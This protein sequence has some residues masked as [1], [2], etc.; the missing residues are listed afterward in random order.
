MGLPRGRFVTMP[1]SQTVLT[2][3]R[4]YPMLGQREGEMRSRLW[5][6]YVGHGGGRHKKARCWLPR[7]Y[8][9]MSKLPPK[10]PVGSLYIATL[11][12][13]GPTVDINQ[14]YGKIPAP[15]SPLTIYELCV[16]AVEITGDHTK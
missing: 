8:S 15:R 14:K 6:H 1:S 3:R 10:A 16:F 5:R 4:V 2:W 9:V 13:S 7:Q 11:P 12:Y